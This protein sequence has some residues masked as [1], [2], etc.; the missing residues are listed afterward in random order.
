MLTE[1]EVKDLCERAKEIL[2][3]EANVQPI[4]A[5]VTVV[6]DIHGQF[7]D[8][9]HMLTEIGRIG[10]LNYIFLGDYVDRGMFSTEVITLL[11]ALKVCFPKKIMLL[12]GNHESRQM[13]EHFNFKLE[14]TSKYDDE[15]Y[16]NVMDSF[17]CFPIAATIE[18]R[19]L[20]VHGG[21]SPSLK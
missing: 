15:V 13:S 14:I 7:Y 4:P 17:E 5:P 12:R 2:K 21:I 11:Y 1:K 19:I 10:E 20:A 18:D 16:Q 8:L 6:G 3:E 9:H